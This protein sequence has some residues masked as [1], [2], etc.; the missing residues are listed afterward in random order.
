MRQAAH[1]RRVHT[2]GRR[3][4]ARRRVLRAVLLRAGRIQRSTPGT[5]A[6]SPISLYPV[7][8]ARRPA[9]VV[10]LRRFANA[11]LAVR[12]GSY[13]WEQLHVLLGLFALLI[14][15][16]YFFTDRGSLDLGLGFWLLLG[17][18]IALLRR[19]R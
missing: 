11:Q 13:T 19:A 5:P 17:G 8:A 10:A 12:L 4:R 6:S 1:P 16:G 7:F 3:R 9:G 2:P 14:A 18:S 15:V